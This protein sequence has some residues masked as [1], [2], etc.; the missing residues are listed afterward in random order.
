MT[1]PVATPVDGNTVAKLARGVRLQNDPVR[2]QAV[3]L[4]P[5]RALALDEI[6][7]AIV[8]ELDGERSLDAIADIFAARFDA[9]K[10]QILSDM[11]TFVEEFSK[12]RML[13]FRS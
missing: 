2:G 4:A 1:G 9:P 7:V 3:L 10:Q 6:A 11:V 13:E 5:E 8:T 12:R